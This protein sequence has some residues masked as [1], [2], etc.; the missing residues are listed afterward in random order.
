MTKNL[1]VQLSLFTLIALLHAVSLQQEVWKFFF[2]YFCLD[3]RPVPPSLALGLPATEC[4][5][6]LPFWQCE[7]PDIV[8]KVSLKQGVLTQ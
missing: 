7:F 5:W 6:R 8:I 2:F 1:M 4:T 3:S